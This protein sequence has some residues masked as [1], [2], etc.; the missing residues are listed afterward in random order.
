MFYKDTD[1]PQ[2]CILCLRNLL[3][4]DLLKQCH[5]TTWGGSAS[6]RLI[7]ETTGKYRK[8]EM[9]YIWILKLYSIVYT[10]TYATACSRAVDVH[11]NLH[12]LLTPYLLVVASRSQVLNMRASHR[13]V[14]DSSSHMPLLLSKH[15]STSAVSR[16]NI[17][18]MLGFSR[19]NQCTVGWVNSAAHWSIKNISFLLAF[20]WAIL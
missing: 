4:T 20:N 7:E 16:W 2:M 13:L 10:I 14:A 6:C 8:T 12:T 5:R 9:I 18:F 19:T 15:Y 11:Y 3:C 17:S 1:I